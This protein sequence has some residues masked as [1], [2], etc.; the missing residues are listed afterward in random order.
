MSFCAISLAIKVPR[1]A[2]PTTQRVAILAWV[3]VMFVL[4]S[5]FLSVF[6]LKN[7]GYPLALP[8]FV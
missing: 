4:Y 8:P 3:G 1:I 5:F 6:R 7:G 2:E